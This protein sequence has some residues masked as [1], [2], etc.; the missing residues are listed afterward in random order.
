M[1]KKRTQ[2]DKETPAIG[3]YVPEEDIPKVDPQAAAYKLLQ[4]M[5]E[6]IKQIAQNQNQLANAIKVNEQRINAVAKTS[7]DQPKGGFNPM[8]LFKTVSE[9]LNSPIVQTIT[10]KIIGGEDQAAISQGQVP[11]EGYEDFVAFR[12]AFQDITLDNLR[13]SVKKMKIG[14]LQA[15]KELGSDFT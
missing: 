6:S 7:T 8:E 13:E 11:P 15:E 3:E 5:G 4:D 10:E 1:A 14:N 12:K 9:I 2:P